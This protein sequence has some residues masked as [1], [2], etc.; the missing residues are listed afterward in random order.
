MLNRAHKPPR[1]GI[2]PGD[3]YDSFTTNDNIGLSGGFDTNVG[4]FG[5]SVNDSGSL[6]NAFGEEI[7]KYDIEV[8]YQLLSNLSDDNRVTLDQFK[9][10][11]K[12]LLQIPNWDD[13]RIKRAWQQIDLHKSQYI[14][15][16]EF[17][18]GLGST[19]GDVILFYQN[20]LV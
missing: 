2:L 16:K 11:I 14:T 20:L 7:T 4:G 19:N 12:D 6:K 9:I 15:F 8:S 5:L 3:E 13:S 1:V 10:W 17:K 18:Q